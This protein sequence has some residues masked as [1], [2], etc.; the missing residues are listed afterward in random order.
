MCYK[1][2]YQKCVPGSSLACLNS[3]EENT[4][5]RAAGTKISSFIT[6]YAVFS[7]ILLFWK[8][9]GIYL[10]VPEYSV[11]VQ[12]DFFLESPVIIL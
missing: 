4:T 2:F 12:R 1:N 6:I 11:C 10:R 5:V 3:R 9:R 7:V 8:R